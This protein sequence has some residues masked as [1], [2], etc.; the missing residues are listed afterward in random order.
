MAMTKKEKLQWDTLVQKLR[1]AAAFHRTEPVAFDVPPPANGDYNRIVNGWSFNDYNQ[2]VHPSCSSS[3]NHNRS[4][5]NK[6]NSQNPI[7]QY[8]TKLLALRALRFAAEEN[9]AV[10][11]AKIDKKIEEEMKPLLEGE[12]EFTLGDIA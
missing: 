3:V 4:G 12:T 8:S 5:W 1:V 7:N 6:T 9:A 11:L 10:I 2:E